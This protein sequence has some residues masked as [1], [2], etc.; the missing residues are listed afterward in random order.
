MAGLLSFL[1]LRSLRPASRQ[2]V[3]CK[4]TPHPSSVFNKYTADVQRS[5]RAAN[6]G[7][8]SR[9]VPFLHQLP[10]PARVSD[11]PPAHFSRAIRILIEGC[12]AKSPSPFIAKIVQGP[13]EFARLEGGSLTLSFLSIAS[14]Q[15][16]VQVHASTPG[17]LRKFARSRTASWQWLP[18]TP[19]PQALVVAVAN[20]ARRGLMI[21]WD[22]LTHDYTDDLT[23][24]GPVDHILPLG[25]NSGKLIVQ[26]Y[27][28]TD[29]IRAHESLQADP[30]LRAL[31][32]S[33]WCEI[34]RKERLSLMEHYNRY[35]AMDEPLLELRVIRPLMIPPA[36][37]GLMIPRV[38]T[39]M[40]PRAKREMRSRQ[41]QGRRGR[42]KRGCRQY[43]RFHGRRDRLRQLSDLGLRRRPRKTLQSVRGHL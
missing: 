3:R 15:K 32:F 7:Y 6:I 1:R 12:D 18:P 16:F 29:A 28:I 17:A 27:E 23:Q 8:T 30:N 31:F 34:K 21:S 11:V 40:I 19:L 24:F 33:D 10:L 25:I 43:Q 37:K 20:G 35:M 4:H 42:Q 26:F 39:L 13:L 5:M 38:K 36:A 9:G 41:Y 2:F 22:P 14:A